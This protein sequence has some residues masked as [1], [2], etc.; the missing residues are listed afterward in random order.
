MMKAVVCREYGNSEMTQLEEIDPPV[1][2]DQG[3]RISVEAS[4]VSF[5]NLLVLEGKHQNTPPLPFTPGTEVA[6]RVLEVGA[7]VQHLKVGDRVAAAV[8]RGGFANEIVVPEHNVFPLPDAVD[9]VTAVHFPTI[10]AMAYWALKYKARLVPGEW[11]L[12]HGAAGGSGLAAIELGRLL[13]AKI[14]ATAST[15]KKLDAARSRGAD[16]ACLS[17][18]GGFRDEVL[19]ITEGHGVDIV[20]DPVGGEVF[21]ESLRTLAPEGRLLIIGFAG[22]TIPKAP[23]NILLVKNI[24]LIGFY[25]GYYLGWGKSEPSAQM[26]DQV[27]AVFAEL[28]AHCENGLLKPLTHE[29]YKLSQFHSALSSLRERNVIGRVA[30]VPDR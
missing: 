14:I 30:L 23:A 18:R 5:A 15:E 8:R 6:G 22:G 26:Y 27:R 12:V 7:D 21:D 4:G 1:M 2:I 10:Y 29:V 28:F 19:R 25:W 20:F 13:G 11:L 17:G 3:T 9:F 16:H 24:A